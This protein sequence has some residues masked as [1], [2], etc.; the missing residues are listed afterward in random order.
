MVK[1][2]RS[3]FGIDAEKQS[4]FTGGGARKAAA[5]ARRERVGLRVVKSVVRPLTCRT[6]RT[7]HLLR[8]KLKKAPG[9]L[10]TITLYGY[11]IFIYIPV[12]VSLPDHHPPTRDR[13]VDGRLC[14]KEHPTPLLILTLSRPMAP[15]FGSWPV[16][17]F[18]AYFRG[19][20]PRL[21]GHRSW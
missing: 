7:V 17:S 19:S 13:H 11:S 1:S 15:S 21:H 2:Q 4:S 12:S 10:D 6:T 18:C 14:T 16:C 20:G 8:W 3:E 9:L 5:A